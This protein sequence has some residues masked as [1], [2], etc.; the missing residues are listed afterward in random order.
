MWPFETSKAITAAIHVLNHYPTVDTLDGHKFWRLLWQYTATHTPAWRVMDGVG[1]NGRKGTGTTANDTASLAPVRSHTPLNA[2]RSR[3]AGFYQ[4]LSA[5]KQT[6]RW[7]EPGSGLGE[8]WVA[9]NGCAD[10][11]MSTDA[12]VI[13]GPAWTDDATLGYR[14][15]TTLPLA[16]RTRLTTKGVQA[17]TT[18]PLTTW[19]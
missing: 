4:N 16:H 7:L 11:N 1:N 2:C 3:A 8:F 12:G 6:A 9:E 15:P 5:A 10:S 19:C 17:T 18:R 13:P 14:A